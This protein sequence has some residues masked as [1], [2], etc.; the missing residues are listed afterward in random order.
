V[1]V[2]QCPLDP[3][4][5]VERYCRNQM[6]EAEAKEFEQHCDAC[7]RCKLILVKEL[8]IMGMVRAAGRAW[9]PKN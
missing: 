5:C 3:E 7:D 4:D 8:A 9:T 6:P 2:D 1:P